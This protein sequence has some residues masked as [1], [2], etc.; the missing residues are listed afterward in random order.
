MR[1]LVTLIITLT[2]IN[3]WER[4][5]KSWERDMSRDYEVVNMWPRDTKLWER[6]SLSW[7]RDKTNFP[8]VTSVP[9]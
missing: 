9:P 6:G 2:L 5:D 4:T 8:H 7:P 3:T 1:Y